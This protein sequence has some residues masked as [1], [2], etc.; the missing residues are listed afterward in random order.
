MRSKVTNILAK[1]ERGGGT[2]QRDGDEEDMERS[3]RC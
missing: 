2:K 1:A 3:L